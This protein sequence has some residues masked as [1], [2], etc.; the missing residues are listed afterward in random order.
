M[1]SLPDM[2]FAGGSQLYYYVQLAAA[3]LKRKLYTALFVV[4]EGKAFIVGYRYP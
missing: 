2:L 3:G 1:R 4:A